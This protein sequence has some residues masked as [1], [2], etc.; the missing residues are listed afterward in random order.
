VDLIDPSPPPLYQ[1]VA[2]KASHLF[3]LG[4][5]YRAIGEAMSIDPQTAS[6]AIRWLDGK[7]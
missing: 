4:M 3:A 7:S 1:V 2:E 5:S 6:K